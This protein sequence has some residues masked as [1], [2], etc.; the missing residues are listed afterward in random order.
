MVRV[1]PGR[2]RVGLDR[3]LSAVEEGQR[4]EMPCRYGRFL[5]GCHAFHLFAL[6]DFSEDRLRLSGPTVGQQR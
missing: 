3:L 6:D 1:E 5:Q 2:G 4:T